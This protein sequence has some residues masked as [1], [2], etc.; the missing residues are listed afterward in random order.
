M[1]KNICLGV[2]T[3][4]KI[5]ELLFTQ[6]QTRNHPPDIRIRCCHR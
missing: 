4:G 5:I 1:K 2:Y 6:N 3:I